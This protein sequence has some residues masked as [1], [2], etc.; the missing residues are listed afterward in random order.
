MAWISVPGARPRGAPFG[1]LVS[2]RKVCGRIAKRAGT[3]LC[4]SGPGERWK[5]LCAGGARAAGDAVGVVGVPDPATV[6]RAVRQ[7]AVVVVRREE[8]GVPVGRA[9]AVD[10]RG[11]VALA[12]GGDL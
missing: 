7:V 10:R 1:S 9:A 11:R 6:R 8:H 4:K 3:R 12:A 2:P 5:L